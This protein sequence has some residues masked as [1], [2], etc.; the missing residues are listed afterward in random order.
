MNFLKVSNYNFAKVTRAFVFALRLCVF[1]GIFSLA[2]H[3]Q[4][5]PLAA[6]QTVGMNA[7]KLNQ[8]DALVK[9]ITGSKRNIATTPKTPAPQRAPRL[10]PARKGWYA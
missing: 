3:A 2:S 9:K 1:A 10:G 7:A 4:G 6:P 8:I 5:L